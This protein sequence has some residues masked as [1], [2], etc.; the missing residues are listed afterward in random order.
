MAICRALLCEHIE[1]RLADINRRLALDEIGSAVVALGSNTA[2]RLAQVLGTTN[3]WH[4]I[5]YHKKRAV[6]TKSFE[7]TI[8]SA[9]YK[10]TR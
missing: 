5:D 1:H 2:E 10:K 3:E 7:N 6:S 9:V 4:V 8:L